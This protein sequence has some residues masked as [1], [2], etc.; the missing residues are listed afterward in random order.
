MD[1]STAAW[2]YPIAQGISGHIVGDI[3]YSDTIGG[4]TY[5]PGVTAFVWRDKADSPS[6]VRLVIKDES[7]SEVY[8]NTDDEEG[9]HAE[10][11]YDMCRHPAV[12]V[13]YHRSVL[14]GWKGIIRVHVV[15]AQLTDDDPNDLWDVY[16]EC[17][18]F[19]LTSS[20]TIEWNSTDGPVCL[21]GCDS[22]KSDCQPDICILHGT[23]SLF[24]TWVRTD[25]GDSDLQ[26]IVSSEH[27][28][29]NILAGDEGDWEDRIRIAPDDSYPKA[30]PSIDGGIFSN[31][32][33]T[34]P[35]TGT[36]AVV[37]CQIST[38]Q[39]LDR[40]QIFY[41]G[42]DPD[43]GC[44]PDYTQ[45]LTDSGDEG[46]LFNGLPK[47]DVP[48]YRADGYGEA[49][50]AWMSAVQSTTVPPEFSSW[51]VEMTAT[52]DWDEPY[53]NVQDAR[54]NR[55][56]EVACY[57]TEG[58]DQ[59]VG[60]SYYHEDAPDDP[61]LVSAKSYQ[62]TI[63]GGQASFSLQYDAVISGSNGWWAPGIDFTG[64]IFTGSTICL[65]KP[66]DTWYSSEF[67]L[68]WIDTSDCNVKLTYGSIY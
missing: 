36:C 41:N 57:Q 52:P 30:A 20:D 49:V 63:S 50:I 22:D 3:A 44:D 47:I 53:T 38:A 5:H 17:L 54:Y 60:I 6:Y 56:P 67:K 34:N 62:Y 9:I 19:K 65:A 21:P 18:N 31:H 13:T 28:Y 10:T 25:P 42:W 1:S 59:Y 4:T 51:S 35:V 46:L 16:Y 8:D 32:C 68:G 15:W 27:T 24:A 11:G 45:Q 40:Y 14:I 61:W 26:Q 64:S 2:S 7:W 37:W 29:A 48:S 39:D 23:G 33:P 58:E 66:E 12:E 43:V 55:C